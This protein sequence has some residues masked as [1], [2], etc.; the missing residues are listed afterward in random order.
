MAQNEHIYIKPGKGGREESGIE[1][2][3]ARDSMNLLFSPENIKTSTQE[4]HRENIN[5]N[6]S[7]TAGIPDRSL[8]NRGLPM[9]FFVEP[10]LRHGNHSSVN[11]NRDTKPW[12]TNPIKADARKCAEIKNQTSWTPL[13][14]SNDS[15]DGRDTSCRSP[16]LPEDTL[17]SILDQGEIN[18]LL[19]RHRWQHEAGAQRSLS[20][21]LRIFAREFL[22]TVPGPAYQS[23]FHGNAA[24]HSSTMNVYQDSRQRS[25]KDLFAPLENQ[26]SVLQTCAYGYGNVD[27]VSESRRYYCRP[28]HRT[29]S[30]APATPPINFYTN[31]DMPVRGAF[32][33]PACQ[34]WH[35]D[36]SLSPDLHTTLMPLNDHWSGHYLNKISWSGNA[37]LSQ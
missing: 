29:R 14:V 5:R 13:E 24:L 20:V 17:E 12:V 31:H 7:S 10:A 18:D 37:F 33:L 2:R 23:P 25:D 36:C 22:R 28:T 21:V 6:K 4:Q 30:T 8:L 26:Q 16:S 19:A 27:D 15:L 3:Y 35:K 34:Q 11:V 9:S 32:S 1:R